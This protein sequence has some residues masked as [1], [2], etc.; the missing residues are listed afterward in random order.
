MNAYVL[1]NLLNKSGKSDKMLGLLSILS[2]FW[3]EFSKLNNK[4]AHM[5]GSIYHDFKIIL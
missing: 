5:L 2:I 1:L 4:G 3:N